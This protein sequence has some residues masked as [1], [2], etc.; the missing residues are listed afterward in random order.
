MK[1]ENS[2]KNFLNNLAVDNTEQISN[3][4][5]E[6]TC[7]LNK[8]FRNNDSKTANT[9]QVGSYGRKTAIKGISDL[10][11][12]YIMPNSDWD[13]YKDSGQSKILCD[14]RDAILERYPNTAVKISRYVVAVEFTNF[15]IEACPVFEQDD[16]SFKY[17]DTYNERKWKITKPKEEMQAMQ[18]MNNNKNKNLYR[19][20]RMARA[21]KNKHGVNMGGLLIDTL[22]YKFLDSTDEYNDKSYIYYDW[23]SRD[24]FKYLSELPKQE[25][26]H[27]PGSNQQVYVK[28]QFQKKA[29]KAYE[30]CLDAIS[31]G[32]NNSAYKK[33]KKVFGGAFPK[34][35]VSE[36][37]DYSQTWEN[38][39]KFIEDEYPV[40]IRY[41][42]KIDCKV[43]P[44]Q[45]GFR[46][47]SKW[48]RSMGKNF[49]LP[50]KNSL[51][52]K[53]KSN[54]VPKPYQVKWKVLNRGDE[55]K[56]QKQI[57]GDIVNDERD[58]EKQE[59]TSFKGDHIVECYI[60][61]KNV[62]VA[63]DLINVP[64]Q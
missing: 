56:K 37:R 1:H 4:Y 11:M 35:Q 53:I 14:T 15:T 39:E 50:V 40:D 58:E 9:L 48:L 3:R 54:E 60:I 49:R 51:L 42:L 55:A 17:P 45:N 44:K 28:Q 12:L 6:V 33:W 25:H 7:V 46:N 8:Y 21:W 20:C 41:S 26:F 57:R 2:F 43:T 36:A 47:N 30:N 5:N 10:D 29:K 13:T 16:G 63:R 22:A 62:V 32:E 18:Y 61:K 34:Y 27:A 31:S 52:F 24:F 64:I 38:T 59:R 19:L 23:M